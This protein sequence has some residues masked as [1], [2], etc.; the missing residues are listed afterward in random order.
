MKVRK[1]FLCTAAST[2]HKFACNQ[3]RRA[4]VGELAKRLVTRLQVYQT[5][6]SRPETMIQTSQDKDFLRQ[7]T[8]QLVWRLDFHILSLKIIEF[9]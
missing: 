9:R 2:E 7:K 8:S 1:P 4:K 6:R 3:R 5:S